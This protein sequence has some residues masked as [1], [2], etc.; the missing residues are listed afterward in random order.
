MTENISEY[1]NYIK[2]CQFIL[3]QRGLAWEEDTR[4]QFLE[5][6]RYYE[7]VNNE[8]VMFTRDAEQAFIEWSKVN[9]VNK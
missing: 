1:D 8:A 4:S 7:K 5:L 6:Y 3:K 9:D 2:A